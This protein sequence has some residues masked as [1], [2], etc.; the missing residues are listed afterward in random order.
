MVVLQFAFA[1]VGFF[2]PAL[3]VLH[4]MNAFAL[5]GIA[6]VAMRKARQ[7]EPVKEPVAV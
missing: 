2:A 4:G 1:V 3:G 5:A 7:T 6:S